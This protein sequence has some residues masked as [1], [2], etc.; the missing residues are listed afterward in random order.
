MP[1]QPKVRRLGPYEVSLDLSSLSKWHRRKRHILDGV[2]FQESMIRRAADGSTREEERAVAFEV[3][4][5][6]PTS[7]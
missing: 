5:A 2:S 4:L 1:N 3:H 7:S 6:Q